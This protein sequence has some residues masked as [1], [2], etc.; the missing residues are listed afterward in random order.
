MAL[1]TRMARLFRAD[2]HALLDQVEEPVQLL[3][4]AV[5]E[6]EESV[7]QAARQ[8][9]GQRQQ[10]D[11]LSRRRGEIVAGLAPIAEQ[12]ELC[13]D[14]DNPALARVL[15]RRQ[16]EGERLAAHAERQL[17]ALEQAIEAGQQRLDEQ[18]LQL[19]RLQQ[20]AELHAPADE[21]PAAPRWS[22]E[23]FSVSDA[24]V[25]LALLRAQRRRA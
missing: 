13:L 15:L 9:D 21:A 25:E 6:M 17:A 11:E 1:I 12:L 22:A 23:E 19:Q 8:L 18:H 7:Q 10:R 14:A 16:L 24:D 20:Q 4:Q 2:L 3:R 5:R